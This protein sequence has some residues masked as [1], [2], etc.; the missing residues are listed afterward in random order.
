VLSVSRRRSGAAPGISPHEGQ[1]PDPPDS[2]VA[3]G[4]SC[5]ARR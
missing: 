5:P 3:R 2:R 4:C 1:R